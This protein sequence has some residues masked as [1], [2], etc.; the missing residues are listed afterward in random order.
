MDVA[1]LGMLHYPDPRLRRVAKPVEDF[2]PWLDALIARMFEIMRD[3][4][5][6]GL[7]APQVGVDLRLFVMNATG[8]AVDDRVYLNPKLDQRSGW[9]EAEEGCLSLPGI[10]VQVRRS[11]K[12]RLIAQD[13]NG[14]PIEAISSGFVSRIWQHEIDHLDGVMIIDKMAPSEAIAVRKVLRSLEADYE[15]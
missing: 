15:E 9:A 11:V 14:K 7:A 1:A 6:V 5:G 3:H 12:C 10:N 13:R 4:K 8:E 2:G